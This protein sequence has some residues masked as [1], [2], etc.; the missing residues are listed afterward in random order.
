MENSTTCK[1]T[2]KVLC[3]EAN[4]LIDDLIQINGAQRFL[5]KVI[6]EKLYLLWKRDGFGTNT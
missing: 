2:K 4:H 5:K 6:F 1:V 3:N